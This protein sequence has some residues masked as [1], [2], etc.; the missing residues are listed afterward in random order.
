MGSIVTNMVGGVHCT[1]YLR[2]VL[3]WEVF[4]EQS[5]FINCVKIDLNLIYKVLV[6]SNKQS[7]RL[8]PVIKNNVVNINGEIALRS[9]EVVRIL[10]IFQSQ[11]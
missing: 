8:N 3:S 6:L 5:I 1:N 9:I 11:R 7:V 2:Q 10:D 4:G